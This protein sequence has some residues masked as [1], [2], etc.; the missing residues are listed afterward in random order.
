MS[1]L[2]DRRGRLRAPQLGEA[3]E[4]RTPEMLSQAQPQ[5]EARPSLPACGLQ[6]APSRNR[7]VLPPCLC[8]DVAHESFF[9]R[10][11]S[12]GRRRLSAKRGFDRSVGRACTPPVRLRH[13]SLISLN[14]VSIFSFRFRSRGSMRVSCAAGLVLAFVSECGAHLLIR[15]ARCLLNHLLQ[16]AQGGL[17]AQQ[18][19]ARQS[20]RLLHN[21]LGKLIGVNRA[22][23]RLRS[24]RNG[25]VVPAAAWRA[26][27]PIE[28]D[29][30][31]RHLP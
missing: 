26:L 16:R 25:A 19:L 15:G 27:G 24:A 4:R 11:A 30:G 23:R 14:G 20:L 12:Q 3:W 17:V 22:L 13:L 31:T 2:A 7:R 1:A 28:A 18:H 10:G 5:I 9:C 21:L 8:L 29:G 6:C